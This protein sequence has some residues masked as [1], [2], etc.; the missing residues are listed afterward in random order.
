MKLVDVDE[1]PPSPEEEP[2]PVVES[3]A[4]I[5]IETDEAPLQTVVAPGTLISDEYFLPQ[6]MISVHPVFD[7]RAIAA[8]LIY[9][10]IAQ[11]AGIEGRVIL[12]LLIDRTGLVRQV[13]VLQEIP[14]DRGFGESAIRAFTGMRVTPALANGEP[15]SCRYRYPLR[16]ILR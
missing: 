13:I 12:E 15:V 3:I 1:L 8:A 5:M 6:H 14:P 10:P 16:F 7:E 9:P 11:R 4:E 2:L